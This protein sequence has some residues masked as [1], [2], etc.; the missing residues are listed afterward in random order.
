MDLIPSTPFVLT[1]PDSATVNSAG[2]VVADL[3]LTGLGITAAGLAI[4]GAAS[5]AAQR[6]ALGVSPTTDVDL[7][8]DVHL[9]GPV[10][11]DVDSV[12]S[13]LQPVLWR[14]GFAGTFTGVTMAIV[15]GP[16]ATG[17]AVVTVAVAGVAC[18]TSAPIE[19]PIASAEGFTVDVAVTAGGAFTAD[20]LISVTPSG[21]N[22]EIALACVALEYTRA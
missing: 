4:T 9:M 19:A 16:I 15:S 10:V 7:K 12:G 3:T 21:T 14:P 6:T 2:E 1:L 22:A 20:Q 18:T 13:L 8:S 11:V 17:P 5:A